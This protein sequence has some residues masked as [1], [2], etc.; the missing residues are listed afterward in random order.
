MFGVCRS[1]VREDANSP[2]TRPRVSQNRRDT[3]HPVRLMAYFAESRP[4][5]PTPLVV[6]T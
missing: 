4:K 1:P 6:P 5:T 3:G 2:V